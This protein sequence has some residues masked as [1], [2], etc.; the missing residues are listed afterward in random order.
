MHIYCRSTQADRPRRSPG[1]VPVAY[2]RASSVSVKAVLNQSPD[3][4][5][6]KAGPKSLHEWRYH[7]DSLAGVI[8][9]PKCH[10]HD[11]LIQPTDS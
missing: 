6:F 3:D 10:V 9:S 7:S 2:D 8:E 5:W 4:H 11:I 1:P